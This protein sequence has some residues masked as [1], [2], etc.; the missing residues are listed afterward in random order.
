MDPILNVSAN[1]DFLAH[2]GV[3]GM[4]WGVRRSRD[5]V[6]TGKRKKAK[7]KVSSVK[8][9]KRKRVK[10]MTDQEL[11]DHIARLEL[12]KKYRD[13]KKSEVSRGEN[14]VKNILQK[15][16]ENVGTQF[17]TFV[18]GNATNK[19]FAEIFN[20]PKIVNPKKGQTDKK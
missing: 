2:Y 11:K 15:S 20:D 13:L 5:K 14:M 7:T 3:L 12:E 9:K 4:R 8:K 10:D 17:T 16:G 19:A 6:S 18:L 1:E